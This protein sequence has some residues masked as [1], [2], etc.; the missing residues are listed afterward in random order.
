M[1][2]YY[3]P[4]S[5]PRSRRDDAP[6]VSTAGSRGA[7]RGRSYGG[8]TDLDGLSRA[9]SRS[10]YGATKSHIAAYP[11]AAARPVRRRRRPAA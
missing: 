3:R 9:G 4:A 11:A 5:T 2:P 8:P 6:A 7:S 1:L 10:R